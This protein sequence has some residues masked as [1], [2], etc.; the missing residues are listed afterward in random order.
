MDRSQPRTHSLLLGLLALAALAPRAAVAAPSVPTPTFPLLGHTMAVGEETLRWEESDSPEGL[1]LE[2]D[3]ELLGEDGVQP[4]SGGGVI[5]DDAGDGESW[6]VDV[7]LEPGTG[8]MWRVRARDGEGSTSAFS[9]L[10]PFAYA[11]DNDPPEPPS[12]L[13]PLDGDDLDSLQPLVRIAAAVDPEGGPVTHR[14]ELDVAP[15]FDTEARLEYTPEPGAEG[16]VQV[17][18]AAGDDALAENVVWYARVSAVDIE[19]QTSSP[20]TISFFVRGG[21]EAPPVP[22]LLR[23][24]PNEVTGATPTLVVTSVADPEGDVVTY[25]FAVGPTRDLSGVAAINSGTR[26]L[27]VTQELSGGYWW[28]ARARDAA[29]ARSDWAAPRYAVAVDPSWGCSSAAAQAPSLAWL[30]AFAG[31]FV[32]RRGRRSDR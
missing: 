6:L 7:P 17:D 29:G 3:V 8:Y 13:S 18:M 4:V 2:Y 24:L 25:E 10:I 14:L 15:S 31:W 11:V 19:E 12:F 9:T 20:D 23:P 26:E 16:E 32:A 22:E 30:L 5:G 21:N 28:T 1:P 27:D